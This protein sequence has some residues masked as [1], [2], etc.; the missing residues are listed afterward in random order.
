MKSLKGIGLLLIANF[1]IMITL[2]ITAPLLINVILP[3]VG[4]DLRGSIDLSSLVWALVFGFGGAF[5]S[6]LFS[7]QFAR[8]MLDCYQIT[9]PRGHAEQ[10]IFH[11]VREIA[12]RLNITMPEVWIYDSPDP[13]AFATGPSRNNS[14]VAVSTGLLNNL[15]EQEVRS[16]LAHEMGHVY[17]GDMFATTVLAGLMNT[18][19][20]YISMWVRRFFA[21][22]DQAGLGIAVSIILQI[23]VTILASILISWFSRRREFGADAFS[24]KV[25]GK[26]SMI[27][28]LRAI[29]NWVNRAQF[30]YD[31]QEPLATMKI[32]GK[33]GG[34]MSLF[35]THPPIEVRIEALQRLTH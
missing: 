6:L 31:T 18:F 16:V 13:N 24:A 32:S 12:Q 27:S 4:I 2:W 21:E 8:A 7:K 11:S 15:N 3:M 10:L 9:D 22:R 25:Y 17:N 28:A 19:V 1:L 5:L 14:M 30:A 23:V 26:D 35:A 29:D 33:A 34:F 20:H